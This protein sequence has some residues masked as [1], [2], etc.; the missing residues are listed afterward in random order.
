MPLQP[1]PLTYS[2]PS[3]TLFSYLG[4][5]IC[6]PDG[7]YT[8]TR[9][10][11]IGLNHWSFAPDFA[12]TWLA[13]PRTQ[14]SL[15]GIMEFNAQNDATKYKSGTAVSFD[16]GLDHMP[17]EAYK[18]FHVGIGGYACQQFTD[19]TVNGKVFNNGNRGR[20]VS[21]GPQLRFDWRM[22]GIVAKWQKEF[23]VE[24]RTAADRFWIQ[25]AVP[26]F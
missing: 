7:A 25:F 2:N 22:G 15:Q 12:L 5:N 10:V 20:V 6:A 9:A 26:I 4:S 19:D 18:R 16:Y 11:N 21:I 1:V 17:F 3:H 14:A 8:A 23:A 13:T 24:N